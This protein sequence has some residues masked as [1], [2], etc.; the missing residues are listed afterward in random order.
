MS[1]GNLNAK[2]DPANSGANSTG[3]VQRTA[4]APMPRDRR[5]IPAPGTSRYRVSVTKRQSIAATPAR[6]PRAPEPVTEA[7][8]RDRISGR[9]PIRSRTPTHPTVSP[10]MIPDGKQNVSDGARGDPDLRR[11]RTWALTNGNSVDHRDQWTDRHGFRHRF[12]G[13]GRLHRRHP[14]RGSQLRTL[15]DALAYRNTKRQPRPPA[16]TGWSPSPTS[17]TPAARRAAAR[18]HRPRTSPPP[19]A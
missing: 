1:T 19:S 16:R 7:E 13:D 4:N 6:R 14:D 8:A 3:T 17:P 5:Q 12:H 2:H 10:S 9:W 15:V 18:I 11:V